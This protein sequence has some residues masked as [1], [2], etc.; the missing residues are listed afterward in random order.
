LGPRS[1]GAVAL[2][3]RVGEVRARGGKQEELMTSARSRRAWLVALMVAGMGCSEDT[4]T[5]VLTGNIGASNAIA[6][7]AVSGDRVVTAAAIRSDGSFTLALPAGN[8]YRLEVLTA[9]GVK[10]V[11][12]RHSGSVHAI[13]FKV[14]APVDPF[15]MGSVAENN[16]TECDG[17]NCDPGCGEPPP[18]C[19]DP[20]DPNC[21]K[22]DGTCGEP[23]PCGGPNEPPCPPP[24]C[25]DPNDPNCKPC[26]PGDP[27]CDPCPMGQ[28]P[29]PPPPCMDP[30][31]DGSCPDPCTDPTDPNCKPCMSG[32][33]NC[34]PCPMGQCPPPPTCMD[35]MDP[36]CNCYPGDPNCDP[37]PPCMDP[38]DPETCKDPCMGMEDPSGCGCTSTDPNCWPQPEDPTC[39]PN[40]TC[41]ENK[42][43]SPDNAPIDFG[44]QES[45]GS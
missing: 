43:M 42:P 35:P 25:M 15:D 4:S 26:E 6:V 36:S 7:R 29:P 28:C 27:N 9:G 5:Q 33:P 41:M 30:E 44:C 2:W 34:D 8:R 19:T 13:A 32:D 10:H 45:S 39:D 12:S 18:P 21:C 24:P 38:T 37:P 31:P 3:R 14:C 11:L 22:P 23:P 20:M 17:P 16:Q 1:T 40:G